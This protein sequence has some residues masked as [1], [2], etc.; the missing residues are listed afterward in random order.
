[1]S[2]KEATQEEV[3]AAAKSLRAA[4]D[5]L[6]KDN[7]RKP[8]NNGGQKVAAANNSKTAGGASASKTAAKTGDAANASI[9]A[10][11]WFMAILTAMIVCNNCLNSKHQQK[12][13]K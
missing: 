8:D 9:P 1:M 2:D 5:N 6:Q 7:V 4:L 12:K 11:V 13:K 10:A 3:D